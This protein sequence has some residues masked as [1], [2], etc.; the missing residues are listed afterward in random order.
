M[1]FIP[2]GLDLAAAP[3][4]VFKA[5][6]NQDV[7][8]QRES[9]LHAFKYLISPPAVTV[10]VP[11]HHQPL[12]SRIYNNF[13]QSCSMGRPGPATM[14]G[15]FKI[16]YDR[17]VQKGIITVITAD[18]RQW[19]EILRVTNDMIEFTGAEVVDLDLPL[20]QPASGL[21]F[22]LAESA[23]FIFTGIRPCQAA[24]GDAARLQR[25]CVPFDL[26]MIQILPGFGDF[27]LEDIATAWTGQTES[28]QE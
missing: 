22:Y 7:P 24:D 2:C 26:A 4:R 20:S 16:H 1:G 21:L 25:I 23:G 14:Q 5:L 8:P 10:Y 17:T 19:P 27:L 9:Y 18:E 11:P 3:P 13:Q 12:L 6:V 15:D 28:P